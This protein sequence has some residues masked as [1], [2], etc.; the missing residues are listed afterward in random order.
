M[1][2]FNNKNKLLELLRQGATVLTPNNRLSASILRDYFA[3][4]KNQTVIKPQCQPYRSAL[5]QHFEQLLYERPCEQHPTLLNDAQ[6]QH[7]WRALIKKNK[8]ITYSEGLL[9]SIMDA[10]KQCQLWNIDV[11]NPLFAYTP[12]TQ[13]FQN[14]WQ[15]CNKI[16]DKL[17]AITEY[18][19]VSY[20]LDKE[21]LLSHTT[22]IW[23][24]F[25]EF[26][27]QQ[28]SIQSY[29]EQH[30]VAQYC[31]DLE[32]Q[33]CKPVRLA[34]EQS[35]V[36]YQQLML[37]LQE[38]VAHGYQHIGVVL[39]ELQKESRS[40]YRILLQ[41]FD[42]SLFDISLG[43]ALSSFPLVAHALSFLHLD[44]QSYTREQITLL[45]QSPYL[46][47]AKA[48]F[49]LRCQYLQDSILI[50]QAQCAPKALNTHLT[51]FAPKL[52]TLLNTIKNYP[53]SASVNEWITLFQ[54]RL[55][56]IEFP[57]DYGLNSEQY[58]CYKRFSALFDEFR[59]LSLVSP[60]L[61]SEEALYAFS[62]LAKHT[63]FQAQKTSAPIQISGLLEASGCEFDSL[64]IMGL[65]DRCLPQS[66]H[67]S[68]FIPHQLQKELLMP[69]SSAAR[70]LQ[71]A[72][73]T[74]GRLERGSKHSMVLSYPMLQGDSPNLP[75]SLITDFPLMTH[76]K[77]TCISTTQSQLMY[78]EEDYSVPIQSE[79]QI[80]G[81]SAL[82]SNQAKCPFKAFAEH[83]LMAKPLADTTE[84]L[85]NKEKGKIIH[86]VME[87]LWREL[88]SQMKLLQ[89]QDVELE[90][91][92]DESIQTALNPL[93]Q[94]DIPELIQNIEH[95][96]LKRLV[97]SGLEW[98]KQRPSFEVMALEESYSITL[99]GLAIKMRVDRLDKVGDKK[100]II[101]YKSSIPSYKPWNEDRP[102]EPQLL[103][104]ALLDEHINALLFMQIKTANILCAG[105]SEDK[106]EISGIQSIK[107]D[108]AW[109]ECRSYWNQQLTSLAEE[110]QAGLCKPQP[111]NNG[112]CLL[113]NF[114][115][116]C[117]I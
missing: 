37:W 52:A 111:I 86:K 44:T 102:Q 105:L 4:D 85:D 33:H 82:L 43:Q 27:P 34:A 46:G 39:P 95:A 20:L 71:F 99:A 112:I 48:E 19:L 81:G 31:Y 13:T 83:R 80:Q 79:E 15:E 21:H 78:Q 36:E 3:Y 108:E 92:I 110:I 109:N 67:L 9:H 38:Q 29:L 49:V 94:T 6:C 17:G 91:L 11:Q 1:Q 64:W 61:S 104:Y 25:D 106:L 93:T 87:L 56:L 5:I 101:D 7:L 42:P 114:K 60:T 45:L 62:Q 47:S 72:K 103:L 35:K 69:H 77:E 100:W 2:E 70:E 107:K 12:Q 68:A 117:R 54:E 115:N 88:K 26:N 24:C 40:L 18:E 116:L 50:R 84:G 113:C 63:I 55:N 22:V 14:F 57:G 66:T 65:T 73:Q 98:E 8:D 76:L 89:I 10:W 96:R 90:H 74:L 41:Y 30:G 59:Q 32:S 97:L 53:S 51:S 16:L 58:Q 23:A 75:C 28:R